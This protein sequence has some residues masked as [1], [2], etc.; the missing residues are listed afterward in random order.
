MTNKQNS[1]LLTSK[2]EIKEYLGNI[3]NYLFK[4]YIEKGMPA[5]F[6]DN[7]WLAHI[8]NIDE[9]LKAY[10]RV[11]MRKKIDQIPEK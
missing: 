11:S 4:K 5:R 10:T 9:F 2:G 8:E 1:K 3:S 6:E 7:R